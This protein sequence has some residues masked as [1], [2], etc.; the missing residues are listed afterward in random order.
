MRVQNDVQR[1]QLDELHWLHQ[2]LSVT[3]YDADADTGAHRQ[4]MTV[5]KV[6]QAMEEAVVA[7]AVVAAVPP[8]AMTYLSLVK[9]A[10]AL[11]MQS[12]AF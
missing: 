9:G 1:F 2:Q 4:S 12:C 7:A 11:Y 10:M 6:G 3:L 5:V 8:V